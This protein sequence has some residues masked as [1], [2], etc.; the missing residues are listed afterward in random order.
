[1]SN[2]KNV[3][4][5]DDCDDWFNKDEEDFVVKIPSQTSADSFDEAG[6]DKEDDAQGPGTSVRELLENL[7]FTLN[8][9]KRAGGEKLLI[10]GSC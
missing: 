10:A 4:D 7:K 3:E 6:D 1:M 9:I 8:G 2:S 5:D